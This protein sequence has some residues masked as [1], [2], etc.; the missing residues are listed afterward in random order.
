MNRESSGCMWVLSPFFISSQLHRGSYT[1]AHVLLNLSNELE[2]SDK[3]QVLPIIYHF[4][5]PS[6]INSILHEQEY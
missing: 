4:F 3:M 1:S 6:L 5:E 2:T